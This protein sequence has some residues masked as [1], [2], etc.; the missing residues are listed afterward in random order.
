MNFIF[1][2]VRPTVKSAKKIVLRNFPLYGIACAMHCTVCIFFILLFSTGMYVRMYVHVS[3]Q[4]YCCVIIAHFHMHTHLTV[5]VTVYDSH[6]SKTVSTQSH[7]S[8]S[9]N[10]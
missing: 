9:N 6:L 10:H 2:D 5:I 8:Q 7:Q 1:A 4:L 3:V